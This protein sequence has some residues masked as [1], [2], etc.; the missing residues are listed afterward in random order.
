[1]TPVLGAYMARVYR[2]EVRFLGAVERG[3]YGVMRVDP[4]LP[5]DWKSYAR[6]VLVFSGLS[7]LAL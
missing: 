1:L 6:T 4:E 7:W 5:Q 3:I 2:G